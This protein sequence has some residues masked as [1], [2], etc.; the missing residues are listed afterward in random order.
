M[1][2]VIVSAV[3]TFMC[4]GAAHAAPPAASAKVVVL[5]IQVGVS[6]EPDPALV[7][8]VA[9]GLRQNARWTVD[10]GAKGR[11][12]K[13]PATTGLPK[14]ER[15][16]LAERVDEAARLLSGNPGKA[17]EALEALWKEIGAL[18]ARAPFGTEAELLR[19][20]AG[21]LLVAAHRTNGDLRR[22]MALA[23]ELVLL[24]PGRK[25]A[26]VDGI[27]A[28]ALDL[29]GSASPPESVKLVIKS[30][31]E[32]CA[33]T[34]NDVAI[35]N[36]PAELAVAP[37][38]SYWVRATCELAK[39]KPPKTSYAKHIV[40]GKDDKTRSEL[41]DA[42]FEQVLVN[43][44][45]GARIKVGTSEE[46]RALE[47]TYVRRTA[48][49][50]GADAVVF[51]SVGELSGTDWLNARL[52]LKNGFKNRQGFVR[53]EVPRATA[54][55]IYLA[56]G[57]EMA[58]VLRRED[59]AAFAQKAQTPAG[60]NTETIKPW[61]TD[62]PGW[63]ITGAGL[64][65]IGVG[66]YLDARGDKRMERAEAIMNDPYT[67]QELRKQGQSLKFWGGVGLIG[68]TVMAVTGVVLLATPEYQG[69]RGELFVIT[70]TPG[71]GFAGTLR[72]TF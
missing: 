63:A 47:E 21:G 58:G 62:I 67:E 68:G 30:Q 31:P 69:S 61:Y 42:T 19:L 54:L 60:G 15:D 10:F 45:S 64:V 5:P 71:G 44:D 20:R 18:H 39:G 16:A 65:G 25:L 40:I 7:A 2:R 24:F 9:E 11:P 29:L 8:A 28:D 56:T 12:I 43:D 38:G 70:P 72:G 14:A 59:A 26:E 34:V 4:I 3:S 1:R 37:E 51:V 22:A 53:L 50:F 57:K 33:L 49:K 46:R 23:G 55:G 66:I 32:G 27:P 48:E 35:G 52:Y 36:A 41:V 6:P 17:V 13:E